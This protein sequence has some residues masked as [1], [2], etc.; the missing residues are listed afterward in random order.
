MDD[1]ALH[2]AIE[3]YIED[4]VPVDMVYSLLIDNP[5]DFNKDD[6]PL[7][8][9]G[10]QTFII[11]DVTI[12]QGRGVSIGNTSK[13]RIGVVQAIIYTKI[14]AGKRPIYSMLSKLTSFLER[15]SF[16]GIHLRNGIGANGFNKGT[17]KV[18]P[19]TFNFETTITLTQ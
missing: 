10:E 4:N 16:N 3:E 2:K 15:K 8:F 1:E 9:D 11:F 13:R 5:R 6:A 17:W 7:L 12:Q 14:D 18:T 19:W